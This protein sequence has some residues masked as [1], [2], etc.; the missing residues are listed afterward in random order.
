VK[1]VRLS[2]FER[3]LDLDSDRLVF[4]DETAAN[5]RMVR[6][7]GRAPRGER[8]Q[9]A[10]SFAH[11]RTITVAAGLRTTGLT[12]TAIFDGP[13]TGAR[14]RGY[15]EET[16]VPARRPGDIGIGGRDVQRQE[17]AEGVHRHVQL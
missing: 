15:V 3:Q 14:F 4:L 11:W 17:M 9:V 12:A 5:T 6:R 10:V 1:A 7:F 13:M 8:C 2:W 16:L